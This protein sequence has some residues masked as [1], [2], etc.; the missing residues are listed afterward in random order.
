MSFTLMAFNLTNLNRHFF[1]GKI[2]FPFFIM[3]Q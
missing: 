2:C 1:S 3:A